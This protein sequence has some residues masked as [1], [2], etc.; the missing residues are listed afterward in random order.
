MPIFVAQ[1][2]TALKNAVEFC[3]QFIAATRIS[4]TMSYNLGR[5]C[6]ECGK[7]QT[8]K[9]T[10]H[11]YRQSAAA[12]VSAAVFWRVKFQIFFPHQDGHFT[13]VPELNT[14]NLFHQSHTPL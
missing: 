4:I 10:V 9:Q 13:S 5:R 6:A 11:S 2:V 14:G 8:L 1:K 12:A 7:G 3:Q